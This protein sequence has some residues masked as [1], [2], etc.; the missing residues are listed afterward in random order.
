MFNNFPAT[1]ADCK[2]I[3][4]PLHRY[5][6]LQFIEVDAEFI[7]RWKNSLKLFAAVA[8][9][10]ASVLAGMIAQVRSRLQWKSTRYWG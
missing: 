8:H 3:L 6:L 5:R 9:W 4:L 7:R 10:D 1:Q 2:V